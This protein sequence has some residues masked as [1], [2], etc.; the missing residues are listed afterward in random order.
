MTPKANKSENRIAS[1]RG[2]EWHRSNAN[3][4]KN[5]YER[6]GGVSVTGH[7]P[8]NIIPRHDLPA[9]ENYMDVIQVA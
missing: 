4:K 8:L 2:M 9:D 5:L 7:N 3:M 6:G 1:G